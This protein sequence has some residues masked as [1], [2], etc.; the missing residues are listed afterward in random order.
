MLR[1]LLTIL[2]L[3]NNTT[4]LSAPTSVTEITPLPITPI[5][6]TGFSGNIGINTASPDAA[7]KLSVNG[8]IRGKEIKVDTEWSDYV[9]NDDYKLKTISEV[10]SYIKKNHHLPD[11]PSAA[12]VEK[13]GVKQALCY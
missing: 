4:S 6:V 2:H 13:N 5:L 8:K 7:Y 11:V 10:E 1:S 3:I 12:E 9:F